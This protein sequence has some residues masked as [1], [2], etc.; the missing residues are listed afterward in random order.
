ML[1]LLIPF[2][3]AYRLLPATSGFFLPGMAASILF[4]TMIYAPLFSVIEEQ[5]P[6]HLK[7][8]ATGLNMLVLNILM[9]GALALAIGVISQNLAA[10][11]STQSWTLPI[12]MADL[13][14]FCGVPMAWRAAQAK[15]GSTALLST[16]GA[17]L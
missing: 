5:L 3:L 10:A 15:A 1:I 16:K 7:A 2:I 11:G 14:A 13:I 9:I 12:L 6:P 4:M 8:T 17:P